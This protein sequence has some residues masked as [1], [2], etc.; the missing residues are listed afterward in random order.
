MRLNF[1]N[2]ENVMSAVR[3]IASDLDITISSGDNYDITV[4]VQEVDT[5]T[6]EV[7]LDGDKAK[8][9]YGNGIPRF[10]RGLAILV[11]WIKNGEV[12]NRISETA[13]FKTNGAM[14]DMSRNAVMKVDTVKLLLRKMALMGLNTFMLYT[15]DTYE[16]DEYPYFGYMRGRYTKEELRELDSYALTLG[17]ELIPC[18]QMLGHLATHLI[19]SGTEKYKDTENA[20]LVGAESTEKLLRAML[21]SISESFTSKRIHVGMDETHDLGTGRYLDINGYK[22]RQDIYLEHLEMVIALCRE[23]G[24]KPMMWSDM[25]F[26]LAGRDIKGFYDYHPDVV[27]TD[28]VK[29]KIPEGIQQVFWDYYHADER[30]YATNIEKHHSLFGDDT[31]FAGGIWM[32]SGHCPL[33]SRSLEFTVPALDACKKGSVREV[34]A[35]VWH[36]GAESMP[37][38]ALAGLA[39]YADYDYKGCFDLA[40]VKKCFECSTGISYDDIIICDSPESAKDDKG[41]MLST[42]RALLYNDPLMGIVDR[43]LASYETDS[44]YKDTTARLAKSIN[45]AGFL[46]PAVN[47]IHALSCLLENKASFGVRLKAAYDAKDTDNLRMIADECELIIEKIRHLKETHKHAWMEYNKAFGWEVHD[48]RYGGLIARFETAKERISD[49]LEGRL[50]RI[51]ELEEKRLLLDGN[52]DTDAEPAFNGHFLWYSYKKL[53]TPNIL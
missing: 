29:A 39:W 33:F 47:I 10:L 38:L 3:L 50:D 30:F 23:Y 9:T 26:K 5:P 25:F 41:Y 43:H 36:N 16:I 53:A 20:L 28:E 37:I 52:G 2:A 46:A 8:I 45:S 32:W 19:W 24:F 22:D 15:E 21:K 49:Y 1:L 4:N 42:T 31:V 7:E 13:I 40:S 44:Y 17:I 48:I 11:S 34:I 18:I 51:E 35:T 14:F 6:V 12:K 27:F